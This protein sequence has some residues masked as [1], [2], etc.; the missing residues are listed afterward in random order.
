MRVSIF[1]LLPFM[2]LSLP[3]LAES[4]GEGT[5]TALAPLRSPSVPET[6]L[7]S[8]YLRAAQN[9]LAAGRVGEAQEALEMAQTRILDRS[10]PIGQTNNPS[11]NPLVGQISEARHALAA[12]DRAT[13]MNLIQTAIGSAAAQ[14][15]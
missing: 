7:P 4:A 5:S 11:D 14:G 9:A 2:A 3:A 12:R 1:W 13:G 10:V 8:D 6:A 15:L